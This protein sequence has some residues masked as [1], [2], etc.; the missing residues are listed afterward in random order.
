MYAEHARRQLDEQHTGARQRL[1]ALYRHLAGLI[2]QAED[3]RAQLR[4]ALTQLDDLR[5]AERAHARAIE[6]D[7]RADRTRAGSRTGLRP[8]SGWC[9]ATGS[10][11]GRSLRDR[12]GRP[13]AGCPLPSCPPDC[14]GPLLPEQGHPKILRRRSARSIL[15]PRPLHGEPLRPL[16]AALRRR[17]NPPPS[18]RGTPAHPRG[19]LGGTGRLR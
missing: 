11:A 6:H 4:T 19:T 14:A 15:R 9:R 7:S 13:A 2:E 1:T 10:Q 8:V 12:L 3:A 17:V 16:R 18:G 5:A